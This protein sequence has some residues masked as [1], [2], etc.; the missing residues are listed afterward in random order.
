MVL[1]GF[2]FVGFRLHGPQR[3][4]AKPSYLEILQLLKKA[5]V[6]D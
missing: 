2:G 6:S 5:L 3:D 1:I 4:F